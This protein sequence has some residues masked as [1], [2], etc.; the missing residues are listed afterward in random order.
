MEKVIVVSGG[1]RGIGAAI[2]ARAA[3]DGYAVAV[4]Y[5]SSGDKAEKLADAIRQKGGRAAAIHADVRKEDDVVRLFNAVDH[6]LGPVTA[7]VNNVGG[8][9]IGPEKRGYRI[10]DVDKGVIDAIFDLNVASTILCSREAIRRMSTK[11]GGAGGAIVN[12][13]SDC[14]RRGGPVARKDG[15]GG[16]VLYGS[17][18]AAID[19]FT[20][21]LAVEVAEEGIRVNAIRP[22]TIVTEAHDTDGPDHYKNMARLIPLSRPGQPREVAE[23]VLF[24]LSDKASFITGTHLDVTGGR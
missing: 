23:A 4:N 17:A 18:K 5:K 13:T 8:G 22:A 2:C 14:G 21:G 3:E 6:Q 16:I 12:I 11:S 10:A 1:S 15:V 19:L 20:L 24:L 7:L 9:K